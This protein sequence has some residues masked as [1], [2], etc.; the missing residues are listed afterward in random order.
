MSSNRVDEARRLFD[1]THADHDPDV[2][3]W[4]KRLDNSPELWD[5]YLDW[6]ESRIADEREAVPSAGGD[7]TAVD[8]SWLE[9]LPPLVRAAARGDDQTVETLLAAGSDPNEADSDGWSALHAAAARDHHKVVQR[10]LAAG[11]T[12]DARTRDG[13]TPLLNA[14]SAGRAVIESLLGAGA[15]P[16]AQEERL[17]WRPLDRYAEHANAAGVEL[18]IAA[19]VPVDAEDFGGTTALADA[20]EAGCGECVELLLAAGADAKRT[21]DGETPADLAEKHGHTALARRLADA[22]NGRG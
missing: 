9:E 6:A 11:A 19:G 2:P 18:V 16:S 21:F 22:A 1:P 15:D 13:F 5:V 3:I 4:V 14:A 17:G 10:L 8:E 7:T 12:V 20:A